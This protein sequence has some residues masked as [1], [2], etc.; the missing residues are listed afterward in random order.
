[1]EIMEWGIGAHEDNQIAYCKTFG[2]KKICHP[3]YFRD[4]QSEMWRHFKTKEKR[5]EMFVT[6]SDSVTFTMCKDSSVIRLVDND[7]DWES[8]TPRNI[9]RF[10]KDRAGAE[11]W[12]GYSKV[13]VTAPVHFFKTYRNIA[14]WMRPILFWLFLAW[15]GRQGEK[16]SGYRV[17]FVHVCVNN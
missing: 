5:G 9:R 3:E 1:M 6:H 7:L 11:R 12:K 8:M 14:A 16:P 17:K 10:Y 4:K 13:N 2:G 15:I